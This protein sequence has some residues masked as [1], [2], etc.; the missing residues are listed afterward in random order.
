M[1]I[2]WW[3]AGVVSHIWNSYKKWKQEWSRRQPLLDW[4][5]IS[6]KLF[7]LLLLLHRQYP[8]PYPL[9]CSGNPA[10]NQSIR[11]L[12]QNSLLQWRFDLSVPLFVGWFNGGWRRWGCVC[13]RIY[14][15]L[16]EFTL[17]SCCSMYPTTLSLCD[18]RTS[19]TLT[20]PPTL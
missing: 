13:V 4:W 20:T 17:M 6:Y 10:L 16:V 11:L 8:H 9:V 7:L 5:Q 2:W 14:I 1:G 15:C 3:I 18:G 12:V 19:G